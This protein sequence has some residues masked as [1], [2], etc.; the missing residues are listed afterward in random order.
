[1]TEAELKAAVKAV[2]FD[3]GW[4]VFS[5][6]MTASLSRRH[7][8]DATGYPDMTLARNH[9]VLW[10]ELKTDAGSLSEAQMAWFRHL[11]DVHLIRPGALRDG[12]VAR[13]L[14]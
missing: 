8:K 9:R 10:L 14:A 2:A 4:R 5:L 7:V 13:L 1:M 12:T 3:R 11:P 6:P